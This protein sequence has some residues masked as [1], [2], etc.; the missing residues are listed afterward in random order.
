MNKEEGILDASEHLRKAALEYLGE[1]GQPVMAGAGCY[2]SS[3]RSPAKAKRMRPISAL[4]LRLTRR[5]AD[6][7][8]VVDPNNITGARGWYRI[9]QRFDDKIVTWEC[10][11]L[12]QG[13]SYPFVHLVSYQTMTECAR[14]GVD[15][16]PDNSSNPVETLFWVNPKQALLK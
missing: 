5:L 9:N 11:A 12:R 1:C 4:R 7:G 6:A 14:F 15:V 16:S 3:K 13:T 2:H 8:F 10:K